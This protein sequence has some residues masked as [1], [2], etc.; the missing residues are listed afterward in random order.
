MRCSFQLCSVSWVLR[1][2]Q[3]ILAVQACLPFRI[4]SGEKVKGASRVRK[5]QCVLPNHTQSSQFSGQCRALQV[6]QPN[7]V[8]DYNQNMNGVDKSDHLIGKYNSLR[9]THRW[10]KTGKHSSTISSALLGSIRVYIEEIGSGLFAS[11]RVRSSSTAAGEIGD[12]PQCYPLSCSG[13]TAAL[14][15]GS[16]KTVFHNQGL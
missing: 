13:A 8:K 7:V 2:L 3:K 6:R 14:C 16:L 1:L 5:G 4:W 10:W 9:K 15:Q 12:F 11:L